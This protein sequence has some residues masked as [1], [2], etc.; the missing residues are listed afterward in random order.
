[1]WIYVKLLGKYIHISIKWIL[2]CSDGVRS[3]QV[4]SIR[5]GLEPI[6]FIDIYQI[7]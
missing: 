7:Q 2:F 6:H 4:N 3:I 1:M 5:G